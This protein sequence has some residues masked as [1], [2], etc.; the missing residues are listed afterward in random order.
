MELLHLHNNGT[1]HLHVV[2]TLLHY[3][4]TLSPSHYL[5]I[6]SFSLSLSLSIHKQRMDP[7]RKG[8]GPRGGKEMDPEGK[9]KK[10]R[11][12]LAKARGGKGNGPRGKAQERKERSSESPRGEREPIR[13][14]VSLRTPHGVVL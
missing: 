12:V 3:L 7:E 6:D 5:H 4:H 11:N 8:D 10:G 2:T 9:L 1:I 13:E 14:W